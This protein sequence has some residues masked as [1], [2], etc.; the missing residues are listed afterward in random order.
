LARR[1]TTLLAVGA[2]VPLGHAA[3]AGVDS[4]WRMALDVER[5]ELGRVAVRKPNTDEADRFDARAYTGST[6]VAPRLNAVR[7]VDWWGRHGEFR[8]LLAPL[9]VR[10]AA[11]LKAPLRHDGT[12]FQAGQPL[13]V[14]Y[15]FNTYR[16]SY[17]EP[18]WAGQT[19]RWALRWGGTLALRDARI[20]LAQGQVQE[21]FKNW[22]PVPLAYFSAARPFGA[23]LRWVTEADVFP[24]PGGG[25]L[26]DVATGLE[27]QL[28][29]KLRLR[30]GWRQEVGGAEAPDFFNALRQKAASVGLA[31]AL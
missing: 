4:G 27:W 22:G 20:R 8:V 12:V 15:K 25:G 17:T 2:L 28:S 16:F 13:D 7:D 19:G 26:L 30:A 24:A 11:D 23:T 29:P 18:S 14:I 10:G 31:Y 3:E 9:E 6:G 5:F 21:D 1:L